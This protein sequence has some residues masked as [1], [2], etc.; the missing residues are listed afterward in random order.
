[1]SDYIFPRT[2]GEQA[3]LL[4]EETAGVSVEKIAKA[5]NKRTLGG[6]TFAVLGLPAVPEPSLEEVRDQVREIASRCGYPDTTKNRARFD[7]PTAILLHESLPAAR[8]ELLRT[9]VWQYFSCGLL[10]DVVCWRWRIDDAEPHPDRFLGGVR[11][12]FGRLWRR[13]D[14]LRDERLADPW[15]LVTLLNEDNVTAIIERPKVARHGRLVREAARAFL[16]RRELAK[17]L[18]I[19]S[20][21]Q[22]YFRQVMMRVT[23]KGAHLAFGTLSDDKLVES[24]SEVAD[25]VLWAYKVKPVEEARLLLERPELEPVSPG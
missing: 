22:E 2:S 7:T 25:A 14:V 21:V 12:A 8:G 3:A 13:A 24:I 6:A 16:L 1:M 15:T 9:D 20:P 18:G 11:N 23:R 10:P 19:P 5:A 17:G 4:I